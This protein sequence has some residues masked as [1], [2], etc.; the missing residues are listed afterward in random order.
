MTILLENINNKLETWSYKIDLY[1][2]KL[3]DTI[4]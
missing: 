1:L 4:L 2:Y 3:A